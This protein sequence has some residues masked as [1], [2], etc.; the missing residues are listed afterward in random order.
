MTHTLTIHADNHIHHLTHTAEDTILRVL[1]KHGI[2]HAA[3]CGGHGTCGHCTV[4]A[5]GMI[6]KACTALARD[7]HTVILPQDSPVTIL[8]CEGSV[9]ETISES[10]GIAI[11]IGTTTI[12]LALVDNATHAILATTGYS[13]PLS[14]Y[15]ADVITRLHAATNGQLAEM[16]VCLQGALKTQILSLIAQAGTRISALTQIVIAANTTMCHLLLGLPCDRLATAPFTPYRTDY[17]AI[18]GQDFFS[19]CTLSHIQIS[20]IPG[21]DAFIGGDI[22]AGLYAWNAEL[23]DDDF[24]FIDLGTNGEM[25]LKHRSQLY[26]ASV[27]AGPAFEGSRIP[28]SE[29]LNAL[30]EMCTKK[31][32]DSTGL[33]QGMFFHTGYTYQEHTFTQEDIRNIQLA[34]ASVRAGIEALLSHVHMSAAEVSHI[35]LCGGFGHHTVTEK[36]IS[37]G[38]LP[39]EFSGKVSAIGNTSLCGAVK[40][41]SDSPTIFTERLRAHTTILSLAEDTVYRNAYISSISFSSNSTVTK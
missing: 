13:N 35:Y 1:Q 34:K 21:L 36:A 29:V 7:Y 17:P 23:S 22:V 33:L 39:K 2:S 10:Y 28:A 38:M 19:D 12:A 4:H 37:I 32:L 6:V 8:T 24:L 26:A 40:A 41:L 5:D 3:T 31:A 14:I 18:S 11:D 16:S 9:T 27:A 20:I 25:V 30:D 15:G